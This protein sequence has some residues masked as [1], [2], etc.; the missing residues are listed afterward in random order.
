[1]GGRMVTSMKDVSAYMDNMTN[2]GFQ[3]AAN[4]L[5]YVG[6]SCIAEARDGGTYQDRTGNLRSSIG[7]AVI[8]NGRVIESAVTVQVKNGK[9]GHSQAEKFL[10]EVIDRTDK[11]GLRLIVTAGMNYA[12]YVEAK[13]YNVLSSAELKGQDL[14]RVLL[15][16]LGF[17]IK[18]K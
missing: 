10:K 7:Y 11:K 13:G 2:R 15:L 14:V 9:A 17:T 18:S 4:T 12:E 6:E 16:K 3:A 8:W 1:M 5:C